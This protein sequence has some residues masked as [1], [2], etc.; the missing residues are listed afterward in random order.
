[1]LRFTS[2]LTLTSFLVWFHCFVPLYFVFHSNTYLSTSL[3]PADM[4]GNLVFCYSVW[5]YIIPLWFFSLLSSRILRFTFLLLLYFYDT[6][7]GSKFYPSKQ[8]LKETNSKYTKSDAI[9]SSGRTG[10]SKLFLLFTRSSLN[11]TLRTIFAFEMTCYVV[12]G[13]K[14]EG[15]RTQAKNKEK[16]VNAIKHLEDQDIK[17]RRE[18]CKWCLISFLTVFTTLTAT[19]L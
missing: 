5:V 12:S 13:M 10:S 6:T 7:F 16:K 15:K 2:D 9:L 1:V 11:L 19:T 3:S 17:S 8:Q 14:E 4:Q 18:S